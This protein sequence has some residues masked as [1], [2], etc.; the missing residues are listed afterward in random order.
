[1]MRSDSSS[2]PASALL[3]ERFA[4]AVQLQLAGQLDRAE[5]IYRAILDAQPRHAGAN[6]CIGMLHVHSKRPAVGLPF[7]FAALE[8]S[9]QI[10]DYWL[11]Y[12]EAL[13]L[14]GQIDSANTA[15]GIA[16]QHGLTGAAVDNF[17]QRLALKSSACIDAA[18][19]AA[20]PPPTHATK[21]ARTEKRREDRLVQRQEDTIK[22]LL[23]QGRFAEA[24][25]LAQKMTQEF[26]ERGIGWK[27]VGALLWAKD[28]LGNG[29]A[30]LETAVRL[31]PDD[32][33]ARTN[34][35]AAFLKLERF[36]EAEACLQKALQLDPEFVS[37]HLHFANFCVGQGRYA[38]AEPSLRRATAAQPGSVDLDRDMR[39]T[40]LLFVLSHNPAVDADAL[41]AEHC[42]V[43]A[44]LEADLHD[45]RPRH[46]NSREPD[47]VLRVGWV[48]GDLYN[49]AVASFIE[50]VLAQLRNHP[51]LELYAYSN[52]TLEDI[53]TRRL[54]EY[55]AQWHQVA[56]LS[57]VQLAKKITADRIDVLIDLSGHTTLNRL[58]TFARKPAPI[59]ASWI[60][61]PGT[62]GLKAMDYYLADRHFLP[63]GPLDGQFTEK[64]VRL[65]ANVPF[66]PFALAPPVNPLPAL[67]AGV[68]TF[69]SFNR[70]GK[71]HPGIIGVWAQLL[72]ALPDSR[73]LIGAL[74]RDGR[75]PLLIEQFAA[76][77][78]A[79][80]RLELHYRESMEIYLALH[81]YVDIC[82]D[83]YPYG[84]GTTTIH[85]LWMGVPTLTIAGST[86]ASRQGAAILGQLGL[87]EFVAADEADFVAKGSYWATHLTELA[88]IRANLRE[89][90]QQSP[91]RKPEV[92]AASLE[93]AIR[94]MWARWCADLPAESFTI[95]DP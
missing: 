29:M 76:A 4:Q 14:D 89:R 82:L 44:L 11:G 3:D 72:R 28:D 37:T 59:Q 95:P 13:L 27:V 26:P 60:G 38:E 20:E 65:P 77:G 75:E 10:P 33:E 36:A 15:L 63:P 25:T 70:M 22:G 5:Q 1:M 43:G 24:L 64:I 69:G 49:H 61:Y 88:E 86:P 51:S 78:I 2:D 54:R 32:A 84:G 19:G 57:S 47:R 56:A 50:P 62:T 45:V 31:L 92:I 9:P 34:L 53:A 40:T 30:A 17:A 21:R 8:I 42:R 68:L 80:Q 7:L 94:R 23:K 16:R 73:L 55:F 83:T 52:N 90:W 93:Q 35:G 18:K 74:R 91:A 79:P 81:H 12:L 41:F 67:S 6:H 46:P 85:A 87:E 48:S 58:R 39:Y 71:L 66:Q